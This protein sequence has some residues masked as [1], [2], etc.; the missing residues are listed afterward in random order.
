M[1]LEIINEN[2]SN[3]NYNNENRYGYNAT[4][5]LL[6][7][8][9]LR[10]LVSFISIRWNNYNFITNNNTENYALIKLLINNNVTIYCYLVS[11]F[12]E[13]FENKIIIAPHIYYYENNEKKLFENLTK[14]NSEHN[15][16]RLNWNNFTVETFSALMRKWFSV[17]ISDRD[18][19]REKF[20]FNELSE[21]REINARY[22]ENMSLIDSLPD[23]IPSYRNSPPDMIPS[24]RHNNQIKTLPKHIIDIIYIGLTHSGKTVSCPICLDNIKKEEFTVSHCGHEYCKNCITSITK[25]AVCRSE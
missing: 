12:R 18:I 17:N 13:E 14:Y 24:Y 9:Q 10:E 22:N 1:S 11:Y 8:I 6:N 3:F 21:F 7:Q 2:I 25:C 16:A 4:I 5:K 19:I 15:S 20:D 23:M